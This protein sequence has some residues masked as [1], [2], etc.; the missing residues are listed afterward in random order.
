MLIQL[1]P[2]QT[3]PLGI[4]VLPYRVGEGQCEGL[5][6]KDIQPHC[7]ID[8]DGRI[9]VGDR[10]IEVNDQTLLDVNFEDAQQIIA[11]ALQTNDIR[12]KILKISRLQTMTNTSIDNVA[13]LLFTPTKSSTT[14]QVKCEIW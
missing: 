13:N 2:L 12:L 8:R 3:G 6:I 4:H 11:A 9:S 1:D 14:Q 5:I 10:I 7:R